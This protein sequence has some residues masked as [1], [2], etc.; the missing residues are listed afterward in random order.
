MRDRTTYSCSQQNLRKLDECSD[1]EAIH[2]CI[3]LPCAL[4][5][6]MENPSLMGKEST[7]GIADALK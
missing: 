1:N 5:T 2:L 7:M 6:V 4:G 3:V